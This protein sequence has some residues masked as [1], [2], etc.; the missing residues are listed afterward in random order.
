MVDGML[1]LRHIQQ[2][3]N[4]IVVIEDD[5]APTPLTNHPPLRRAVPVAIV[6]Y[7]PEKQKSITLCNDTV[8]KFNY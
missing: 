3:N 2:C 6:K 4:C 7:S 8:T 5:G 1:S